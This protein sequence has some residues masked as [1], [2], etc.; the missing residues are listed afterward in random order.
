MLGRL[1]REYLITPDGKVYVDQPGGNL[2]YAAGGA[3][4]WLADDEVIGLVARVGEDYPRKWLDEFKQF[5]FNIEGI[6]IL[7]ESIDVRKFIAYSDLRSR[8]SSDPIAHFA[9]KQMTFPKS[10]LGYKD[11]SG[12]LDERGRLTRVSIRPAD[13]PKNFQYASIAHLCG[14]DFLTHTLVPAA[15]RQMGITSILIDPSPGYMDKSFWDL[16]PTIMPGLTVFL[17]AEEDLRELF[18]GRSH[19]LWE[20]AE[21]VTS[22]G[23]QVVVIK[24]GEGGQLIYDSVTRKKYTVPAYPS[25]VKDLTGAGEVFSG[26]FM[27][28]YKHTYSPLQATLYGSVA[29]SIAVENSGAFYARQVLPGLAQAR[30]ERL[31]ETVRQV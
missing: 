15:L 10:L 28:G 21:A 17:P 2:L 18:A 14:V 8:T 20:M 16:V 26:G 23:C 30:L 3:A 31:Q 9:Q 19:D 29:A 7:P 12:K 22:W 24:R 1:Q 25:E 11:D 5:G 4:L 13:I 6:K 27:V